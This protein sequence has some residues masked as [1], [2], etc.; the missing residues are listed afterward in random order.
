MRNR[1]GHDSGADFQSAPDG[2]TSMD[3]NSGIVKECCEMKASD[4]MSK[5]LRKRPKFGT[6]GKILLK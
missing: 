1:V 2:A 6:F 5:N 4:W 3:L